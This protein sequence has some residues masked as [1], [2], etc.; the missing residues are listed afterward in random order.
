MPAVVLIG[1]VVAGALAAPAPST[2]G[3]AAWLGGAEDP[4]RDLDARDDGQ[5]LRAVLELARL[6]ARRATP[7]LVA[8]LTDHNPNVRLAAARLLARRGAKEATDAAVAWLATRAPQGQFLGLLVLRQVSELTSGAR[9]A[10][11]RALRD[12]DLQSRLQ[13]LDVLTAHPAATSFS[14]V[15]GAL[16]DELAEVRL[17]A[18]HAFAAMRDARA[19]VPLLAH[20]ADSDRG[21]R[22]ATRGALG[23]LGD[24]RVLPALLRQLADGAPE[25][26]G[27]AIDAIARL[28][29][30][31][32]VPTL[33]GL[34]RRHPRDETA[35]RAAFALGVLATPEAVEALLTLAR[36]PP[37]A[38]D[39]RRALERAGAAAVPRL[40]RELETGTPTSA[41][42]AAEALGRIGDRGATAALV[43]AALRARTGTTLAALEALA[44]L[45]DPGAVPALARLAE[46]GELADLRALALDALIAIGDDRAAEVLPR[47]LGD[48]D[49]GVRARAVRLAARLGA[50]APADVLAQRLADPDPEVRLQAALAVG[51][52]PSPPRETAP[53]ILAAL[54][55]GAPRVTEAAATAL[56]DALE[57]LAPAIQADVLASA[58]LASVEPRARAVLARALFASATPIS[59]AV[60]TALIHDL[61]AEGD[62]ACAAADALA[63]TTLT[64]DQQRAL[65]VAFAR[66]E[67]GLAAR[68][69]P[70]MARFPAGTAALDAVVSDDGA[71]PS[72][73]AAA[74]WARAARTPVTWTAVRLTDAT[75]VPWPDR[76]VSVTTKRGDV[77]RARTDLDGRA[78]FVGLP[79]G[80]TLTIPSE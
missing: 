1:I 75:G 17:R 24:R 55:P 69:A 4:A 58:Y 48:G 35:R 12:G 44:R 29:D 42:L 30:A 36:E 39:V 16:D 72:V 22:E 66:A 43:T 68:L 51:R 32:A 37:G 41:R 27:E 54:A 53:R 21:V 57:R 10:T 78:V 6:D 73:R 9:H 2:S 62:L 52:L 19:S 56:G 49:A 34:A 8:R 26:R 65:A 40:C 67:P 61:A 77:A 79:E 11:E 59:G 74:T 31:G 25:P 64:R 60:A 71:P 13:A 3:A 33:V 38:A 46:R 15:A 28:G 50:V 5:R 7:L 18:V 23:V 14:A 70:A 20:V 80:V 47:A 45:A 63:R 76:S